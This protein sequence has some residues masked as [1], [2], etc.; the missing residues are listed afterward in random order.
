[1]RIV[2][3]GTPDF[4]VP[5]LDILVQA[6]HE[7]VAVVTVP[8]RKAG[9]G[10]KIISSPVKQ[11]AESKNLPLL[12][13]EKLRAP[14]FVQALED[15]APDLMIV[16]AFRMLPEMVWSIPK[17]GT[18]NLHASL[19]PDY[20]G[21]A[22]IN[23]A[24]INGEKVTGATTFF[25]DKKID[26]GN[27]LMSTKVEIPENWTAGDLHDELMVSGAK[28]VL[29][30]VK[31]LEAGALTPKPQDESAFKHHAPKIFKEDCRIDWSQSTESVYNKI[32]GLSPYPAAWTELAGK[33]VKL[34]RA[35]KVIEN[36]GTET[37]TI[38]IA[39]GLE[40]ATSDGWIRIEELQIAGKKRMKTE[41]FLR[42][43]K[44][45]LDKMV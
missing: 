20:R 37:G 1:M 14:E 16:V 9:R 12:Q 25:I 17:I 26:T 19:L 29:E 10:Q 39:Q 40:V 2:F 38:R 4:A 42:G 28:L 32:R 5:S 15:L 30:T 8:D 23:W 11:Y 45:D 33:P 31:G 22:P 34:Y 36:H 35:S 44:G 27:L 13:P 43:H 6:G 7:I 21:A 41:D 24:I 18:F 3:M